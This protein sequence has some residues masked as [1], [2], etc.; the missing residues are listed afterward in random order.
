MNI[1]P[2]ILYQQGQKVGGCIFIKDKS[3]FKKGRKEFITSFFKCRC[4]NIF[5]ARLPNIKSGNT[6]SCGC[7]LKNSNTKRLRIHGHTS[8]GVQSSEFSTWEGMKSRCYNK[9]QKQ[10]KDYGGRGITVCD[11]WIHSFENFLSDM[12]RKPTN[13]YSIDRID[14]NKGYCPENCRWV[15]RDEQSANKRSTIFINKDGKLF[16]PSQLSKV[17]NIPYSTVKNRMKVGKYD[18]VNKY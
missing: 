11:R 10:Y 15:T 17:Y 12:G 5:E 2:R 3:F 7:V 1:N 14:N 18:T 8:N 4:G 9:N 13:K 6:T 16:T